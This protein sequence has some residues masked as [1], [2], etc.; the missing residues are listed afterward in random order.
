MSTGGIRSMVIL[1]ILSAVTL[2]TIWYFISW[3]LVLAIWGIS[4]VIGA[5]IIVYSEW[6]LV[7]SHNNGYLPDVEDVEEEDDRNI[8]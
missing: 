4:T 3:W 6:K 7:G 5:C 1:I 8:K 2:L